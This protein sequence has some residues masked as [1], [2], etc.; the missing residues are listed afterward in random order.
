MGVGKTPRRA[1]TGFPKGLLG[2]VEGKHLGEPLGAPHGFVGEVGA[3]GRV[4]GP[5]W[6]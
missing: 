4:E 5:P 2:E 3:L 1:P 6:G